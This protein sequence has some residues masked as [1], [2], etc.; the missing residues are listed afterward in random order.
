MNTTCS[1]AAVVVGVPW[2]DRETGRKVGW[3]GSTVSAARQVTNI[4]G[5]ALW[6]WDLTDLR[7]ENINNSLAPWKTLER[8]IEPG[9]L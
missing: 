8:D 6:L 1:L 4:T 7:F 5:W 3:A 9:Y 2:R